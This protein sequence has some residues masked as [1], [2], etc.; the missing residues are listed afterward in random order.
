MAVSDARF[1][2]GLALMR[3]LSLL[4]MAMRWFPC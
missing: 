1:S 4:S 2:E 3:D